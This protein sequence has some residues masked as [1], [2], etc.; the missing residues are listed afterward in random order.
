MLR[1]LGDLHLRS[2]LE[3]MASQFKLEVDTRPPR[4]PYRETV[5]A[6]AEGHHR[7]KKQTGGAGQFGEVFLRIEPLPRGTG[8]EFV[9]QVKGGAIPNTL[10]PAVQKGVEQVLS[11]GPVAGFPMQDVRVIVYDGKYHPV[12]SKEVAFVVRRT[13]GVPRRDRESETDHARADRR[14]RDQLPA[15]TMGDVDRR[16]VVAQADR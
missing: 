1:G 12:D 11:A 5:T 4:V 10:I 3:R 14:R 15:H 16:P 7:H 9:D 8:F 6:K 13:Q 2:V